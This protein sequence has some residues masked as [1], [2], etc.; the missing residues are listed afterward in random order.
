MLLSLS[1]SAPVAQRVS[2]VE[3]EAHVA[4]CPLLGTLRKTKFPGGCCCPMVLSNHQHER[5]QTLCWA[6]NLCITSSFSGP[7][8]ELPFLLLA[9]VSSP[10]DRA[11]KTL[12][13]ITS[14][15]RRSP[16]SH[17]IASRLPFPL[18]PFNSSTKNFPHSPCILYQRTSCICILYRS[19]DRVFL[20]THGLLPSFSSH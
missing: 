10:L 20:F 6:H 11:S 2:E 14:S 16:S 12:G 18:D 3:L 4:R 5:Q 13:H 8:C 1:S 19:V 7:G 17:A 15:K 9:E